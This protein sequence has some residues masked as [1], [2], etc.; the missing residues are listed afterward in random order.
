[1]PTIVK[2]GLD[3]ATAMWPKALG[4]ADIGLVLH[5]ASINR[6]LIHASDLLLSSN[7]FR[8]KAFFGPQ[9][10]LRGETQ[11]NMVEWSGFKD[12]KTGLPVF[13]LYGRTRK[14]ERKMLKGID[15]MVVD[16]QDVGSRYY[17]FIWTLALVME[18]CLETRKPVVI[19]D[20]PNPINGYQIEGPL[21]QKE[22]SSFVG[23]R[24][25]PVRHG[26][27]VGEIGR[28]L[29][30]TFYPGLDLHVIP[31]LGWKRSQW[32]EETALPWAMPSPNMPTVETAVVYPG[33]CL[34]E[35]TNL[36]EGR[37]TTRPFE[38]FGAPFINPDNLLKRLD[39]FRL[40]GML[41]RPLFFLPTFQKHAGFLCGGAQIHVTD[42]NKYKPF[43]TA[44]AILKAIYELYPRQFSW[45]D[46]PYE[47]EETLLPIDI[48][49][50]CDRFRIDIESGHNLRQMEAW[51]NAELK[52][53]DI[54]VRK[55]YL[56]YS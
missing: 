4:K 50:G 7:K 8:V 42:R 51:W 41:F 52:E 1:M 55:K 39:D 56:I 21:L 44:A 34:L 18:A 15:V 12:R 14:P 11:D 19:L 20:R 22:F 47:Y 31:L 36:S 23:L 30:N 29:Q 43:Y 35:G 37:G 40:P 54:N 32:F 10:G 5:P 46:P 3:R 27:T 28:Y 45:K 9:H 49:A 2:T 38:I 13:S 26:M 33:M 48:L 25:L 53:F 16:L 17:T 6:R 24:P